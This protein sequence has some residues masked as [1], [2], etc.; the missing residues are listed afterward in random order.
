[1]EPFE[2]QINHNDKILITPHKGNPFILSSANKDGFDFIRWYYS[3]HK[4]VFPFQFAAIEEM[5]GHRVNKANRIAFEEK[6][7]EQ[8][9]KCT[10]ATADR[11]PDMNARGQFFPEWHPC[12][13]RDNCPH[14]GYNPSIAPEKAI[15]NPYMDFGFTRHQ[16]EICLELVNSPLSEKQIAE[17]H[18]VEPS[19]VSKHRT[20]IF[21]KVGV[22]SRD[23]LRDRLIGKKF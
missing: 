17:K 22:V 18:Y 13:F 19:T 15:C 10:Y 4:E 1:M 3:R 8:S 7:V 20:E 9:C 6:V 23:Q 5:I 21:K 12:P 2:A 14:N 11:I 16:R